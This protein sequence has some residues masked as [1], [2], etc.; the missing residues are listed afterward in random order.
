MP[1]PSPSSPL[2]PPCLVAGIDDA[3]SSLDAVRAAR[4]L[5][6]RLDV[7][8]DLVH[9]LALPDYERLR[10]DRARA[11]EIAGVVRTRVQAALEARTRPLLP[12]R[13]SLPVV[14]VIDGHPAAVLVDEAR[15]TGAWIVLGRHEKRGLFEFENTVRAILARA[16]APV[17]VQ[18]GPVRPIES[19]LAAVDSSEDSLRALAH[20]R[21][22]ALVHRAAL[23]VVHCFDTLGWAVAGWMEY[24][25]AAIIERLRETDRAEFGKHMDTFDWRGCEHAI[26]IV[27]ASPVE[28]IVERS[29]SAGLV[30]LGT[31]G[32]TGFAAVLGSVAAGVLRSAECPVLAVPFP[33]RA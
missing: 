30:V 22:L 10:F 17:W 20:A 33:D 9:A 6:E 3:D 15:R 32:K 14:R 24:G 31:H 5:G 19:V 2:L 1:T 4:A 28:A 11:S 27:D 8:V 21:E 13:G 23:R 16:P 7:E 18:T 12:A 29:R 25:G 26:E